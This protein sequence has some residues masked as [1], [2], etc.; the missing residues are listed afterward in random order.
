MTQDEGGISRD[1]NGIYFA[2]I[3]QPPQK[4]RFA[5]KLDTNL[6]LYSRIAGQNE[7]KKVDKIR[8][9]T[10]LNDLQKK[11]YLYQLLLYVDQKLKPSQSE[12][13][14]ANSQSDVDTMP[15]QEQSQQSSP[16]KPQRL[17]TRRIEKNY[18]ND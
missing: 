10:G 14:S 17:P 18:D 2:Y 16:L 15:T 6:N 4:A 1:E 7:F 12:Q 13:Q 9:P 3:P 11:S 8:F 5:L